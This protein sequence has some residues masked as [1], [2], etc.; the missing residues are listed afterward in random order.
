MNVQY[1]K[2]STE[3]LNIF[4]LLNV[5][6]FFWTK[7]CTRSYENFILLTMNMWLLY[8]HLRLT[9]S[10]MNGVQGWTNLHT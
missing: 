7:I 4:A 1:T 5:C 3:G 8:M 9:L 6:D 10:G 2:A